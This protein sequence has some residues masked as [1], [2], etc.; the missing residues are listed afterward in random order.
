MMN[1]R[2]T[3]PLWFVV[4]CLLLGACGDTIV[5]PAPVVFVDETDPDPDPTPDP[6]GPPA[7]VN[8]TLT[9]FG[10]N[11][12]RCA[13]DFE[14]SGG[15][16]FHTT[17]CCGAT[18]SETAESSVRVLWPIRSLPFDVSSKTVACSDPGRTL[19]APERTASLTFDLTDLPPTQCS[20]SATAQTTE[21]RYLF[22]LSDA[23]GLIDKSTCVWLSSQEQTGAG[24]R[25][26]VL[27]TLD[28][29]LG[30][31]EATAT[32]SGAGGIECTASATVDVN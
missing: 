22:V 20:V 8:A 4:L 12:E 14:V 7:T 28:G 13:A 23:S 2:R 19:C 25:F 5:E 24:D 27:F 9:P 32:C 31:E 10:C 21:G 11:A 18:P 30:T 1:L 26:S 16:S 6:T 15:V 17:F 29:N 3:F